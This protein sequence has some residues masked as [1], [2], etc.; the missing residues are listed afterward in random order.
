MDG[1]IHVNTRSELVSFSGKF[2]VKDMCRVLN[3]RSCRKM[4]LSLMIISMNGF[5][6][7]E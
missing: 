4:L 1:Y 3:C 2:N 5:G 6:E 7:N